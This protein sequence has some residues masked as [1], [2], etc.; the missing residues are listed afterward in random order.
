[1]KRFG[2]IILTTLL[3]VSCFSCQKVEKAAEYSFITDAESSESESETDE[4]LL[5]SNDF[6]YRIDGF[7]VTILGY[8]GESENIV[9]PETIDNMTVQRIGLFAFESCSTIKTVQ[10]PETIT[11]IGEGAFMNCENLTEINFP[12]SL[13]GIDKGAFAGC[14]SLSGDIVIPNTVKYIR[15]EA[16]TGCEK[17]G[18]ITLLNPDMVYENWGLEDL[19]DVTVKAVSGSAVEEWAAAMGKFI[20]LEG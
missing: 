20:A 9:I 15:D 8:S 6:E 2:F 3:I 7:S 1:M 17:I 12:E 4:N 14:T 16:F 11:L 18:T 13:E 19:P 5:K 10:L